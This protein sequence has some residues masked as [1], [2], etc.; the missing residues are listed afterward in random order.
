M[1]REHYAS[2]PRSADGKKRTIAGTQLGHSAIKQRINA[3]EW[4][5]KANEDDWR[6]H[7]DY[8]ATQVKL[9]DHATI[10]QQ[11][12]TSRRDK[13]NRAS[14]GQEQ[15]AMGSSSATLKK[16]ELV[17]MSIWAL[18]MGRTPAKI[19]TMIRDRATL[20]A[21]VAS[22]FRG[23]SLRQLE[24]SDLFLHYATVPGRGEDDT[25]KVSRCR[26]RN[27]ALLTPPYVHCLL[28]PNFQ[29]LAFR[30]DNS[31]TN[32]NGRLDEFAVAR[33]SDPLRCA[34]AAIAMQAKDGRGGPRSAPECSVLR[35]PY[36]G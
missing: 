22:A 15:K 33:H 28:E 32:Q 24:W 10:S 35:G 9:R 5:R 26:Q 2:G 34:V 6:D 4:F 31:K 11:E 1:S 8:Q 36:S 23:D 18:K 14:S 3:L 12:G 21:S 29:L 20:L 16:E 13:R 27:A 19:G 30:A 17:K 25:F 7:E